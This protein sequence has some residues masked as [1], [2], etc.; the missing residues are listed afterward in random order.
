MYQWPDKF[1]QLKASTHLVN[2][3]SIQTALSEYITAYGDV[4]KVFANDLFAAG[5]YL[6][7]T[8][9]ESVNK[10]NAKQLG[11]AQYCVGTLRRVNR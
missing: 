8:V 6:G 1:E 10:P 3:D 7:L 4:E 5:S 2:S 9:Y 11:L